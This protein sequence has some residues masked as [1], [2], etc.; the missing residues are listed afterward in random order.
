MDVMSKSESDDHEDMIFLNEDL[1]NYEKQESIDL[2]SLLCHRSYSKAYE[3]IVHLKDDEEEKFQDE[4]KMIQDLG[5]LIYMKS[6][7]GKQE[8]SREELLR[9]T[10]NDQIFK[11]GKIHEMKENQIK[12]RS[13]WNIFEV[14]KDIISER[15]RKEKK[16]E[17]I[18]MKLKSE[19]IKG[20]VT[21]LNKEQI[22]KDLLN[23]LKNKNLEVLNK[24]KE[25]K[26]NL[27]LKESNQTLEEEKIYGY[28][29]EEM[30]KNI[31][32]VLLAVEE[33]KIL[34]EI[35]SDPWNYEKKTKIKKK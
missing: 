13:N 18:K 4:D 2:T 6:A 3:I 25:P 29:E 12:T 14:K 17:M 1:T 35:L 20:K 32:R 7:M 15:E 9:E 22:Q 33:F 11:G 16:D 21:Q 28:I 26:S 31:E 24:I 30:K 10:Y 34:A 5:D 8:E 19:E 23:N 27:D